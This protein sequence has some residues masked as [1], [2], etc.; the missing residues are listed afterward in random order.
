MHLPSRGLRLSATTIL[1]AGLF[2]APMRFIRIRTAIKNCS[3]AAARHQVLPPA[4]STAALKRGQRVDVE[5]GLGKPVLRLF[6]RSFCG[7][8]LFLG[9]TNHHQDQNST[10]TKRISRR[11]T[12]S[13]RRRS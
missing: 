7:S 8:S 2:L 9:T 1:K 4:V 11:V 12:S 3:V 5:Q 6:L 10:R 13:R